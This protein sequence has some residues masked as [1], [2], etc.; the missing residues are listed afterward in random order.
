VYF[1]CVDESGKSGLNDP[2]QP[3]HVLG[4]LIVGES[5]WRAMEADLNG[6]IDAIVSPPRP[7][8]WELHMTDM[9][10]GKGIFKSMRRQDRK[11]LSDP[12]LDVIDVTSRR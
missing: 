1:L 8:T 9:V 7:H 5:P 6:R 11:A 4:G 10:N 2:A 12:V 3:Y